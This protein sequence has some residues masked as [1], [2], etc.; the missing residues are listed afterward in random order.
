MIVE[1]QKVVKV[2]YD[3]FIKGDEP[4]K[5]EMIERATSEYP[6]TYCHGENMMLPKFEE[7]LAGKGVGDE[8]D[9]IIACADAYGERDEEGVLELPKKLFFNGDGEF[10][11]ERVYVGNVIPMNTTD[12]QIVNA[13]VLEITEDKV[14]ID[15]NHPY[16]GED[17]HFKGKILEIRDADPKELEAIR[18]PKCGGCHGCHGGNCNGECDGTCDGDSCENNNE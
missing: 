15:L 18:H 13:L 1:N 17:L 6:L 3:L 10:D 4:G 9:F 7:N 12:G 11:A 8:F 16:A 5:E 14:T 2:T